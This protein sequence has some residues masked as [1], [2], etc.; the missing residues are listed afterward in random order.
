MKEGLDKEYI[1]TKGSFKWLN[2]GILQYDSERIMLAAQHQGL[3]T[4][5]TLNAFDRSI[6]PKC[7]FGC[8]DNESPSHLLSQCETLMKQDE[9]STRHN[10]LCSNIHWN[11]LGTFKIDRSEKY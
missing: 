11:I 6:D 10:G 9:Y 4:R 2:A 3:T 8:N 5:T 7:K 1:D